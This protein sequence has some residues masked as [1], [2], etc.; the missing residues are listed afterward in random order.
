[1]S[2]RLTLRTATPLVM[3]GALWATGALAPIALGGGAQTPSPCGPDGVCVPRPETF[4]VYQTR[5][6]AFPGDSIGKTPTA[7]TV[8]PEKPELGGPKL[9]TPA[10]EGRLGPAKAPREGGAPGEQPTEDGGEDAAAA[11]LGTLP[12]EVP[13][14][15]I[16][17]PGVTPP[18]PDAAEGEQ[19]GAIPEAGAVPE[20]GAEPGANPLDPFGSAPPA[21]PAWLKSAALENRPVG[22][23]S[24]LETLP[25]VDHAAAVDASRMDG[26]NLHG[27]DAPPILPPALRGAGG[28]APMVA[29]KM[30]QPASVAAPIVD[31]QVTKASAVQPAG[32]Q[33]INPAAAMVDPE[34]EGPQQAIYFEV[35]DQ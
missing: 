9:P 25:M 1:M 15:G 13:L 29:P 14:P 35:S 34:A 16:E 21:P 24:S 11:G 23:A 32:I 3:A 33:L 30:V 31:D 10:E 12:G 4:G 22:V 18:A 20:P 26:P 19:S 2:P 6:R 27:D 5:W 8:E 17:L 28:A 7:A